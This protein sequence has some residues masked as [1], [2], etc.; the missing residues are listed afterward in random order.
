MNHHLLVSLIPEVVV[1]VKF[2][3]A[4]SVLLSLRTVRTERPKTYYMY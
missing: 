4:K 1:W 3:N 2:G